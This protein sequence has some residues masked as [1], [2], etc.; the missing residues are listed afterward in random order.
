METTRLQPIRI[1]A[2]AVGQPVRRCV[3]MLIYAMDIPLM[4]ITIYAISVVALILPVSQH[5]LSVFMQLKIQLLARTCVWRL[6]RQRLRQQR[7]QQRRLRQ[8]RRPLQL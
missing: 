4:Q 6:Q 5:V 3:T 2:K 8:Q 1:I 7:L